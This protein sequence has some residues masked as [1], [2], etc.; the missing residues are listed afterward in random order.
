MVLAVAL[1]I[2]EVFSVTFVLLFFSVGALVVALACALGLELLSAQLLIFAV[3]SISG[4]FCLRDRLRR[5]VVVRSE[6]RTDVASELILTDALP[7]HASGPVRYRG[8]QWTA[9]NDSDTPLAAGQTVVIERIEGIK[10]VVR[11]K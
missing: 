1:V 6:L 8:T 7:A 5:A 11:G 3:V 9:V 2:A 10:L 4:I